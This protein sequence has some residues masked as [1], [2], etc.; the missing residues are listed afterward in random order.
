[1]AETQKR[2][3]TILETIRENTQHA[4]ALLGDAE[5]GRSLRWQLQRQRS[6]GCHVPGQDLARVLVEVVKR[7][8]CENHAPR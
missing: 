7:A 1:M 2:L 5:D 6:P 4:L 3:R 8:S